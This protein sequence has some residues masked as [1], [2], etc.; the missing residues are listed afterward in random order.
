[1]N[2]K[3]ELCSKLEFHEDW[4]DATFKSLWWALMCKWVWHFWC[5]GQKGKKSYIYEKWL[6][7]KWVWIWNYSWLITLASF[8]QVLCFQHTTTQPPFH[9][10]I[11]RQCSHCLFIFVYVFTS[12]PA[13]SSFSP[14]HRLNVSS[15]LWCWAT[16]YSSVSSDSPPLAM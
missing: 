7:E 12:N 14:L 1:M 3:N 2:M 5:L 4:T 15:P 10:V 8:S 6:H 16:I 11:H 13:L 9:Q